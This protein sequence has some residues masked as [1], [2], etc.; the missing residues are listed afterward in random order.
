MSTEEN[1]KLESETANLKREYKHALE[2]LTRVKSDTNDIILI[3]ERV[4]K[5]IVERNEDLTKI[6]NEISSEKLNWATKRHQELLDIENQKSEVQNVLN[7]KADL[8]K[9]EEE[10]RKIEAETIEAR[11]EERRLEL[12]NKNTA[13]EFD[14]REKQ[15]KVLHEELCEKIEKFETDKVEF[16]KKVV[17]V[18]EEVNQL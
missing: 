16:R 15:I 8:N 3:K 12:K 4:T 2:N 14:N 17:K 18:L 6:F 1:L 7:W 11:N 9:K 10:L 5:E 13:L